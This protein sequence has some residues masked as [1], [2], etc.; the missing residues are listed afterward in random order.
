MKI[1]LFISLVLSLFANSM[2]AQSPDARFSQFYAA[3][4][5]LNPALNGVF[6]GSF[7]IVANYR[8]QWA[9][10]LDT[11]PYRTLA[12]SFDY[13]QRVFDGD[14][15]AMGFDVL[16]DQAGITKLRNSRANANFSYLK[17]L[18]GGRGTNYGQY[19]IAGGQIG[20]G[21]STI[22]YSDVWFT[23]QFDMS[24]EEVD[25]A[26]DNLENINESSG[27]YLNINAGLMWY[28]VIDDDF[29]VY[30]GAAINH[31]NNPQF[32]FLDNQQHTMYE[33]WI[34]HAGGQLPLGD[35]FSIL[36]AAVYMIQGPSNS[37]TF[38]FNVRYSNNDRNELA[39]RAGAWM[40]LANEL[41]TS[42]L[43]DA[44]IIN[45]ALEFED[46]QFGFSYD[47]NASSLKDATAGRGGFEL[48]FIYIHPGKERRFR[49]K[50]PQF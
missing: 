13:R 2:L 47:I 38:G 43:N 40:H 19:L 33:K 15:F 17:K 39:V 1:K 4:L 46:Y 44:F 22:D 32:S 7:R 45:G 37:T 23:S 24:K 34:L 9:S 28:G 8:D 42:T 48:S 49:V 27:M 3:P 26:L 20:A 11:D 50:C 30:A 10:I 21:Q 14:Y 16:G 41:T 31:L 12:F 6:D 35:A 5:Q 36:P 25:F 18:V 29:S